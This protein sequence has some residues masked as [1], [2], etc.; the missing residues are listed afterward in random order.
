MVLMAAAATFQIASGLIGA[1]KQRKAMKR[2]ARR[3]ANE[4]WNETLAQAE[5]LK[6]EQR[7]AEELTRAR[8]A[9]SGALVTEGTPKVLY[10]EM[11]QKHGENVADLLQAGRARATSIRQ[12]IGRQA[13]VGWYGSVIEAIG[14][15]VGAFGDYQASKVVPGQNVTQT[16]Y[17]EDTRIIN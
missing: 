9:A 17:R 4:A 5:T 2:E 14:Q 16:T 11:R 15:S 10:Q 13:D 6:D 7:Y 8:L 12:S 1:R 3:Q